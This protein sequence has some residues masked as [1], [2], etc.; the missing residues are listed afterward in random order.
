[1]REIIIDSDT[2][3]YYIYE[4]KKYYIENKDTTTYRYTSANTKAVLDIVAPSNTVTIDD[5]DSLATTNE[6]LTNLY[7]TW[8]D[9]GSYLAT[10]QLNDFKKYPLTLNPQKAKLYI[11][12]TDLIYDLATNEGITQRLQYIQNFYYSKL[13]LYIT[14][15]DLTILY[16]LLV[17]YYNPTPYNVI[18]VQEDKT[19]QP[20]YNNLIK[21]SNYSNTSPATY[22]LTTNPNNSY[23]DTTIGYILSLQNRVITLTNT[24]PSS[25]HVG[26]TLTI[27]NAITYVDGYP[28]SANGTYTITAIQ[29]NTITV[30]ENFPTPYIYT[31][32]T[33]NLVAYKSLIEEVSREN[34]TITV[35]SNSLL[36]SF[37]IGDAIHVHGTTIT[38][39]YET[40]TVDGTYT[41]ADIQG[42]VITV[43]EQPA[44]NYTYTTGTQPYLYKQIHVADISTINNK[45]ITL[46]STPQITLT[47]SDPVVI[48]YPLGEQTITTITAVSA[49]TIT[50]ADTLTNFTANYGLL[51]TPTPSPNVLCHVSNTTKEQILPNTDFILDSNA[52][53]TSYLHLLTTLTLP[54]EAC[55][56][57]VNQYVENT[58]TITTTSTGVSTMSFKGL[59]SEVYTEEK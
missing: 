3:V 20:R 41:I 57:K 34:L 22:T 50:V 17:S 51:N 26:D 19:T 12:N 32:P 48:I 7:Y 59:Y 45:T 53:A 23:T 31:P 14:I 40:L 54:T 4:E 11:M 1:M 58:Y 38:T 44:T 29:D 18:A 39:E 8:S 30:D 6:T 27:T 55:Y 5:L 21:L 28:Y 36:N 2:R 49:N 43:E 13:G 15:E 16:N 56:N 52:Q 10:I 46:S 9:D 42:H 33:L 47:N 25:I 35:N 24:V 37:L